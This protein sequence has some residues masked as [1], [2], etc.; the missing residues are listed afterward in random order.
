M[1][2]SAPRSGDVLY[3]AF[4]SAGTLGAL[5]QRAAAA[6][7]KVHGIGAVLG[8]LA[9]ALVAEGLRTKRLPP[10]AGMRTAELRAVVAEAAQRLVTAYRD[11]GG[12]LVAKGHLDAEEVVDA[13]IRI[14][15][16]GFGA[17]VPTALKP[18][19]SED[20]IRARTAV[21]S[22]EVAAVLRAWRQ[23][24]GPQGIVYD[25]GIEEAISVAVARAALRGFLH[26]NDA[27]HDALHGG[28]NDA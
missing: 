9:A 14:Y 4:I 5:A 8:P 11:G 24:P 17:P 1:T 12:V 18:R 21:A 6:H 16:E 26:P 10:Q 27:I 25:D 20:E 13:V 19:A 2:T 7:V 15:W 3:A 28:S 23:R 22:Q